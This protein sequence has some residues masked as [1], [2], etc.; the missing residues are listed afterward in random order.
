VRLLSLTCSAYLASIPT[1]VCRL[2]LVATYH[3]A[4]GWMGWALLQR[5]RTTWMRAF[6]VII[7]DRGNS[8]HSTAVSAMR[9]G[10]LRLYS[11]AV[12]THDGLI[13]I[14]TSVRWRNATSPWRTAA[15]SAIT[16]PL[17]KPGPRLPGCF[18]KHAGVSS[19]GYDPLL[20]TNAE[21]SLLRG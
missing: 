15:Q 14:T 10:A 12:F 8:R 20:D 4:A 16:A 1:G 11:K 2:V 17:T 9:Q 19:H 7:P 6:A 13:R 5:I 21:H 3:L 18:A